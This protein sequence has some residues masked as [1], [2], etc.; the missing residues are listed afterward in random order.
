M[1]LN[2][3]GVEKRSKEVV[4]TIFDVVRWNDDEDE[5]LV[6]GLVIHFKI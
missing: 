3:I 5:P 4:V 6:Y 2:E 1:W